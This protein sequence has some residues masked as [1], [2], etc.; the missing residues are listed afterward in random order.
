MKRIIVSNYW[1][2]AECEVLHNWNSLTKPA[3]QSK[4]PKCCRFFSS[5][6]HHINSY[7]LMLLDSRLQEIYPIYRSI[8][9]QI[10]QESKLIMHKSNCSPVDRRNVSF[11]WPLIGNPHGYWNIRIIGWKAM[12]YLCLFFFFFCFHLFA[13]IG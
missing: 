8:V 5:N 12:R 10:M 11:Q 4:L 1:W 3:N 9:V 7:I 2:L 6:S 13:F